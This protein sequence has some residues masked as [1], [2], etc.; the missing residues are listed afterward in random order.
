MLTHAMPVRVRFRRE[1]AQLLFSPEHF[2][3]CNFFLL[4]LLIKEKGAEHSVGEYGKIASTPFFVVVVVNV[5]SVVQ[6]LPF[7]Q[8]DH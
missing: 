7:I 4:I 2:L 3:L 1:K 6:Y 8:P 5:W